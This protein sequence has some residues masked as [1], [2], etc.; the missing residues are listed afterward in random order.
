MSNFIKKID[1]F[2]NGKEGKCLKKND[3]TKKSVMD[4]PTRFLISI[5]ICYASAVSNG[6]TDTNERSFLF[7]RNSTTPSVKA[8]KVWSLPIPTFVPG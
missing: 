3:E 2:S 6:T 8:N 4:K 1:S 7:L 5:E